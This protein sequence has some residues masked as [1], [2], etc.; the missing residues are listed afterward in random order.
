MPSAAA[1]TAASLDEIERTISIATLALASARAALSA[2]RR[3]TSAQ[4]RDEIGRF[5]R[6]AMERDGLHILTEVATPYDATA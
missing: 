2:L 5:A 4:P 1:T 6:A 3:Q